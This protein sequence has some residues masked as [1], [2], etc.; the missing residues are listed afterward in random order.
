LCSYARPP[1]VLKNPVTEQQGMRCY[2]SSLHCIFA[3]DSVNPLGCKVWVVFGKVKQTSLLLNSNC[4][5]FHCFFLL[6]F[7]QVHLERREKRKMYRTE[8]N[9]EGKRDT[10]TLVLEH[11]QFSFLFFLIYQIHTKPPPNTQIDLNQSELHLIFV[12]TYN[13]RPKC[14]NK[15][16]QIRGGGRS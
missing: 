1:T 10:V 7:F 6:F 13:L 15:K 9:S 16:L 4:K 8:R 5:S 12:F 11:V 3:C 14:S 2:P